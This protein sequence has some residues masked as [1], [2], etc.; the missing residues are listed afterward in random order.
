MHGR[1]E[2]CIQNFGWKP[3]MERSFGRLS[4]DGR[5]IL[6]GSYGNMVEMGGLDLF[7]SG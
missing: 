3:E 1:D 6:H 5:I 7:G 4:H 2:K